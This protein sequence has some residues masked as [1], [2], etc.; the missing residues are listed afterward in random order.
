MKGKS[1]S[2]LIQDL[3]KSEKHKILNTC[4]R[5]GD[6][7]HRLLYTLIKKSPKNS[8]Q[9]QQLLEQISD[10]LFDKPT[11]SEKDVRE[12]DKI[13]RRFIDFAIKEI[14]QLKMKE[15][16]AS[17][18][19]TRNYLLSLIY[20]R[21]ETRPIFKNYL[22]KAQSLAEKD[23]DAWILSYCLDNGIIIKSQ[24]QK[25]RDMNDL[26]QL[27]LRKNELIQSQYH[28]KLS[29][30]Y[31]LMSGLY[32]NDKNIINDLE[33]MLLEDAEIDALVKLSGGDPVAI[34]YK[35]AQSRFNLEDEEK[36]NRYIKEAEALLENCRATEE[37]IEKL[38]RR[39]YFLRIVDGFHYGE[40]PEN[41][42]GYSDKV[43]AINVKY[44]YRDTLAA[45]YD[46]FLHLLIDNPPTDIESKM[47]EYQHY[48]FAGDNEYMFDFIRAYRYFQQQEIKKSLQLLNNLSYAPNFYIA[49]WS[50]LLEMRIHYEKGNI[51]L[52]ES[53][54]ERANRQMNV[55]QGK[56]FTYNSNAMLL[57]QFCELLGVRKPRQLAEYETSV[58]KISP[59]HKHLHGWVRAQIE[60]QSVS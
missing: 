41:L 27:L 30:V 21:P 31:N 55:N 44:G 26:R 16:L 28:A 13:I 52:C 48:Y 36:L 24:S 57:M 46:L 56:I 18:Q 19:K 17:D 32:L 6:K 35:I 12:K 51:G 38:K 50:R 40:L 47:E 39:L 42:I 53:L 49:I 5:S 7:R 14:E 43:M 2:Q 23:N 37:Q 15:F 10:E 58:E 4:K 33:S 29:E 20:K 1:L 60:Q 45:F 8:L 25:K 3:N 9:Y 34:E 54:V 22:R 59:F 11:N